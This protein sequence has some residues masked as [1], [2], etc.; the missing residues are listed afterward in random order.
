MYQGYNS[1]PSDDGFSSQD[2][3]EIRQSFGQPGRTDFM[4]DGM[5]WND[6]DCSVVNPFVCQKPRNSGAAPSDDNPSIRKPR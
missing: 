3:V 2:C 6:R 5:Y 4:A 1:Q